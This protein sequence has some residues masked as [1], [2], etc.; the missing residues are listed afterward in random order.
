MY[1]S[2]LRNG[3][4]QGKMRRVNETRKRGV[5][6]WDKKVKNNEKSNKFY[7]LSTGKYI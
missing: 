7:I 2:Y 5:M 1:E 3:R 6:R 4:G